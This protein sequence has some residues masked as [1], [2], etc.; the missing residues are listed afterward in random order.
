MIIARLGYVFCIFIL[1]LGVLAGESR[2]ELSV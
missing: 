1:M 2:L